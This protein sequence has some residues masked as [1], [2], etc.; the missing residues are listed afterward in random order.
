MA[1]MLE[2]LRNYQTQD[3]ATALQYETLAA[4]HIAS[5][6]KHR[7]QQTVLGDNKQNCA[8][9]QLS[10]E[11]FKIMALQLRNHI[12]RSLSH[13]IAMLGVTHPLFFGTEH[14]KCLQDVV[15][16][17]GLRALLSYHQTSSPFAAAAANGIRLC[18]C[19]IFAQ[20][21]ALEGVYEREMI[22]YI[23]YTELT[24][25][26]LLYEGLDPEMWND[27]GIACIRRTPSEHDDEIQADFWNSTIEVLRMMLSEALRNR[28]D[29]IVLS[30]TLASDTR[31][32]EAIQFGLGVGYEP[33]LNLV[34]ASK[35]AGSL[36]IQMVDPVL[37]P[38]QGVADLSWRRNMR[39]C[40]DPC[41]GWRQLPQCTSG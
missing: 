26:M 2:I 41:S 32:H 39:R 14:R 40:L 21:C 20:G 12:E 35:D 18:K 22:L 9:L 5:S 15:R 4:R 24:L 11:P 23:E 16:V 36:C 8:G 33:Y 30:G 29:Y 31:L 27:G 1:A 19:P 10:F 34:D 38:A 25:T 6:N 17:A 7:L 13:P 28:I 37:A 3:S